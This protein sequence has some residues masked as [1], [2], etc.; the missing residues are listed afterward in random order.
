MVARPIVDL[1]APLSPIRPSTSPWRNCRLTLSTRTGPGPASVQTS[2]RR[3]STSRTWS[4][5]L[6]ALAIVVMRAYPPLR[7]LAVGAAV[8]REQPVHDQVHADGQQRDGA[9]REERLRLADEDRLGVLVHHAAPVLIRRLDAEAEERQA[10][11][12]QE[13]EAEAQAELGDQ[14]RH[15]IGQHLAA[16]HP[17]D[18]LATE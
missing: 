17:P 4:P 11:N 15:R 18:I 8:D 14:R 6:R 1:P 12:Q 10:R 5:K 7:I 13:G 3:S 9:G 16:D 2:M